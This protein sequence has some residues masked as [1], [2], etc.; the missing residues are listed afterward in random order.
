MPVVLNYIRHL[1]GTVIE[2]LGAI[3][4]LVNDFYKRHFLVQALLHV[5][6]NQSRRKAGFFL[7]MVALA[8]RPGVIKNPAG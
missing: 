7:I 1:N 2:S 4:C 6:E 8:S 5:T 3:V